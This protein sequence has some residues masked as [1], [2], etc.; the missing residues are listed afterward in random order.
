MDTKKLLDSIKDK[1]FFQPIDGRVLIK[2]LKI[3][4]V[5]KEVKE[6][7]HEANKDKDLL[8]V[9]GEVKMVTKKIEANMQK[10]IVLKVDLSDD[11]P[12]RYQPGDVVVYSNYAGR[13]F[14]LFKDSILLQKYE[15]LGLWVE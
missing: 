15:I 4:L 2:P 5:K 7:D 8:K 11:T 12:T 1:I 14:E 10:G 3:V 6:Q 9:E 13:A